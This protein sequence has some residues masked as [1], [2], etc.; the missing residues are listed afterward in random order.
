VRF[1][2]VLLLLVVAV[3]ML[4]AVVAIG[5]A[6]V[7]RPNILL[8]S[9]DSLRAD[10]LGSYGYA[11]D[12]S[13]TIDRLAREGV[14]FENAISSAP[15]TIPAHATMLTGLPPEVHGVISW[16]HSLA[17]EAVTLAEILRDA[18]WDTAAFVSGPTVVARYGFDQGFASYDESMVDPDRERSAY[19]VTSPGLV[20][21]VDGFLGS[22]DAAGRT[23]PFFVFL[24]M[25]DVHYDYTPPAPW[26]RMFDPDYAGDVTAVDFERN[27]R[28]N[29]KMDPRDLAHVI[30]LYDGEI[31]YT[32][33]HLAMIVARLE[34]LGVLDDTIVVVTSDHGDEFFEHGMKGHAKTL[35]DE[36]LHVPLVIR[37]PPRIAHGRRVAEQVRMMDV[38]PTILGLA[39]VAPPDGFGAPGMTPEHRFADLAPFV[40]GRR[41]RALPPLT[42]FSNNTVF[43]GLQDSVRTRDAKLIRSEKRRTGTTTLQVFDLAAD[44]EEKHDLAGRGPAPAFAAAL[45]QDLLRWH[46]D[47]GRQGKLAL[48]LATTP[49]HEARL[50]ALGYIQ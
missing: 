8:V 33:D 14:V 39:R 17:P 41:E 42:A 28:L 24:H 47:T 22:W 11:R 4:R 6:P 31:R 5:D 32:D 12:T 16:K 44:P 29:A 50:R 13:P 3:V 10:H 19:P 20:K 49:G 18:G 36:V 21:L 37:H 35:Y 23:A 48:A 45:D 25:W 2:R 30:A 46:G 15:W 1:W 27:K 38:A 34:A 7:A 40:T 9:I 43:L 26:N